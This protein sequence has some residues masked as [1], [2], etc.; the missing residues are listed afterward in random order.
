M[1]SGSFALP[2]HPDADCSITVLPGGAANLGA[3]VNRWRVQMGLAEIA[4]EAIGQLPT[5]TVLETSAV[6][7][8]LDGSYT[9][10]DTVARPGWKLEGLVCPLASGAGTIFVKLVGPASAVATERAS[11]LALC[12]SLRLGEAASPPAKSGDALGWSIPPGWTMGP[13]KPMRVA[14]LLAGAKGEAECS[15]TTLPGAAGGVAANLNRWRAQ[16]SEGPL[17]DE[18]IAALPKVK[19][20]GADTPLVEATGDYTDMQGAK[21]EKYALLGVAC[22][23]GGRTVFVKLIG[24]A[25]TVRAEREHF[26]AFLG[27]L[28]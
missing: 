9:G 21:H 10:M 13:P 23:Q 24:P 28:H 22:P 26:V 19:V 7:V 20:L 17:G 5:R 14:T 2:E 12:D 25:D 6:L 3:N 15:V 27:S 1:R 16:M 8:E 18:G 11:F 4:P